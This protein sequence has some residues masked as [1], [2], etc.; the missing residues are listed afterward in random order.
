MSSRSASPH[1]PAM[2]LR[3]LH[4]MFDKS[5]FSVYTIWSMPFE[6]MSI[7]LGLHNVLCFPTI[8]NYCP[9]II[10]YA[11]I[12]ILSPHYTL[13]MQILVYSDT[14]VFYEVH[15]PE[16]VSPGAFWLAVIWTGCPL[17]LVYI[18]SFSFIITL[19]IGVTSL[20]WVGFPVSCI[21]CLLPPWFPPLSGRAESLASW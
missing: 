18:L 9:C 3:Q 12:M 4:P 11:F 16:K 10:F 14:W 19:G 6:T 2:L 1:A 13:V 7:F 21:S 5:T 8:N 15:L 20:F 17:C